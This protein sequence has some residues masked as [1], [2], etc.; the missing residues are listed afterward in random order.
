MINLIVL[1]ITHSILDCFGWSRMDDL[2]LV[3]PGKAT[4]SWVKPAKGA[5]TAKHAWGLPMQFIICCHMVAKWHVQF[6]SLYFISLFVLPLHSE[7]GGKTVS[8][9]QA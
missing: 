4:G 5:G 9:C 2:G 3:L 6:Q 8:T 1:L 7:L